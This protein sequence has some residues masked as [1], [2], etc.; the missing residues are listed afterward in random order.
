MNEISQKEVL[1]LFYYKDGLLIRRIT[2]NNRAIKGAIVGHLGGRGYLRV[3]VHGVG[4][5]VHRLIFLMHKGYLPKML[6]HIDENKL[7]NRIENLRTCNNS[8][9]S[10]NRKR[11][12]N[13]TS[14]VKG[15]SL[16]ARNNK[17][18]AEIR[19]DCKPM[20]IGEYRDIN[21]AAE[22]VRA[23]RKEFHGEFVNHG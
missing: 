3:T 10:L 16:N 19:V 22:A 23:K 5:R 6:D 1:R 9:N 13:N 18:R 8:E 21:D 2:I 17:W 4:F 15:V 14:G 11:N 12:K 20:Y 7:N